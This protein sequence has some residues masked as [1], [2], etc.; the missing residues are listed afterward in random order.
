MS[1]TPWSGRRRR[2]GAAVIATAI[3]AFST[4]TVGLADARLA[5]ATTADT[6]LYVVQF[7]ASPAAGYAGGVAGIPATKPMPGDR[8]DA[9]TRQYDDYRQHLRARRT[10]TLRAG[11]I[12]SRKVVAEYNAAVNGLAM[13]LTAAEAARLTTTPG[14]RTVTKQEFLTV[15]TADTPTFLGLTGPGGAWARQFGEQNRAGE[16]VIVGVID[17]GIRPESASFAALPEPRPDAGLIASK[18]RGECAGGEEAPVRCNNKLIGARWYHFGGPTSPQIGDEEYRSPRDFSGH[19]THTAA[20]A[21]GAAGVAASIGRTPVGT[22]SGVAPAARIAAYKVCWGANGACGTAEILRAID[23]AITDGVDVINYSIGSATA[24]TVAEPIAV[25]FYHAAA[26]GVFVAAAAG[27]RGPDTVGNVSPWIATVAASTHDRT[28]SKT[29]TLGSGASFSGPGVGTATPS[30]ALVDS[31]T[32]AREGPAGQFARYCAAGSLDP[33]KTQGKI[34]VC[35]LT[36]LTADISLEV[37]RAGG[38]A[39]IMHQISDDPVHNEYFHVPTIHL[40]GADAD[41]VREYIAA[42]G[43]AATAAM[44]A[45]VRQVARAPQ[46]ASFSSSGP[47]VTTRGDLLKPDISAPGVDIIAASTPENNNG[48]EFQSFSGTSMASPHIAG[49]A[50]LVKGRFPH[51]TPAAVKSALMTTASQIDNTGGPIHRTQ[52]GGTVPATPFDYG[53]GQVRPA[54][55]FDPGVVYDSGPLEWARFVCALGEAWPTGEEP[56]NACQSTHE[57]AAPSD[58]NYPS[59]AVGDLAGTQTIT[60]TVTNTTNQPSVYL[61]QVQAPPGVKIAVTPVALAVLPHRSATYKVE[62]T[63]TTASLDTSVF[64]SLTWSD[65]RGHRVRSPIAVRPVVL[66]VPQL[67]RP[68]ATSGSAPVEVHASFT[69]PLIAKPYGLVGAEVTARTVVG[70][71]KNLDVGSWTPADPGFMKVDVTLPHG[72]R[73]ARFATTQADHP[74]GISFGLWVFRD[75]RLVGQDFNAFSP[76]ADRS[77]TVTQPGTYSVYVTKFGGP[78]SLEVKLNSFVVGPDASG[79]FTVTPPSQPVAPGR[80]VTLT[81]TWSDLTPG[82]SYL[83][84]IEYSDG[85]TTL[86]QTTVTVDG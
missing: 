11:K 22:V 70:T 33:A 31:P 76:S 4:A 40:R 62:L 43:P 39:M 48:N 16:G 6:Q 55:A 65:L 10:Q 47:A 52:A 72:G 77:V 34:V 86:G 21:A 82:R 63:R 60:R 59:I 69:G 3:T 32:V 9:G 20:T 78:Q 85:A 12:N 49:L 14:V 38:A 64:G 5:A 2:A 7:D 68:A 37:K 44:S 28:Y 13:N 29:L 66:A 84:L 81:A 53:A 8:M 71:P 57:P 46:I 54:L 79:N 56:H 17:T 45:G 83:G 36:P 41:L 58:L 24:R 25:A 51:W 30:G 19:G 80:P 75:G 74:H 42:S 35:T 15:Q 18:W 27:N 23:D 73:M 61:A 26:A 67:L 50:A 1:S